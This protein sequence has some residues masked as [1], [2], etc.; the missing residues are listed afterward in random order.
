MPASFRNSFYAGLLVAFVIGICLVRLWGAEKQVRLHSEH[1]VHQVER[2]NWSAV[3]NFVA[4]DYGD[5]WGDDRARL[6][7]RLRLAG[8]FFFDLTI[9]ASEAQTQVNP[10][11]GSW[12]ARIRLSGRGEAAAEITTR[13]NSLTSPFVLQWRRESWKPWDWKLVRVTNESLEI[14]EGEF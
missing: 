14:P 7:T 13:V 10:P 2:R 8:R 4:P 6:L 1:L 9:T 11:Q 12:R 3:E 5:D